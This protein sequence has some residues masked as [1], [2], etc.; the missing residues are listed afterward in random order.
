MMNYNI[1]EISSNKFHIP[2][3]IQ[4]DIEIEKSQSKSL[5]R[6]VITCF[7]CGE[8]GH[9]KSECMQWKTRLCAHWKDGTCKDSSFCSF[10]HGKNEIRLPWISKCVR[11][12][13]KDG[14]II[15][16]GCGTIGHTFR[17][18]CNS[19]FDEF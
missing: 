13:K 12:I 4:I 14:K 10:A 8:Q 18:C 15:K 1:D 3:G 17:S 19:F 5:T 6:P 2:K 11:V 7:R 9:F 16:L